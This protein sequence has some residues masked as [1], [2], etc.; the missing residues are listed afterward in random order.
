MCRDTWKRIPLSVGFPSRFGHPIKTQPENRRVF[1]SLPPIQRERYRVVYFQRYGLR[2][3]KLGH[4]DSRGML[5]LSVICL[6]KSSKNTTTNYCLR[7]IVLRFFYLNN[8]KLPFLGVC[9]SLN[10]YLTVCV[11]QYDHLLPNTPVVSWFYCK[12]LTNSINR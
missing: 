5:L 2:L 1:Y 12:T 6:T 11:D 10:L 3:H 9:I 8:L 7:V 4:H